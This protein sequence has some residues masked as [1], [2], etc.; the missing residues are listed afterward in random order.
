MDG[1]CPG[2][3]VV[4]LNGSPNSNII[5]STAEAHEKIGWRSYCEIYCRRNEGMATPVDNKAQTRT[6]INFLR[7]ASMD[8]AASLGMTC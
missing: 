5:Q 4:T 7:R 6:S 3:Y 1:V 2:L 8:A